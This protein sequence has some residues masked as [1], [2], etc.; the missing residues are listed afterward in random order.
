MAKK[1]KRK[2][3]PARAK[4]KRATRKMTTRRAKSSKKQKR[5]KGAVARVWEIADSLPNAERKYVLA[6]CVGEGININTAKTQY[7]KWLHA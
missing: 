3:A 1:K 6:A 4:A 2:K 5:M 7:Q